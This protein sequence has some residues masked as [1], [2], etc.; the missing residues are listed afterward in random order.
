MRRRPNVLV[1][2]VLLAA[3]LLTVGGSAIAGASSS[4]KVVRG[5]TYRTA[6]SSFGLTDNL[7]PTGEY[8]SGFA[9]EIYAATLRTL[10]SYQRV[11]GPAG[12]LLY[13]DLATSMPTVTDGG[14][15]YTFHLK[16][17]IRF[18]PPVNS[19][20]TSADILFAFQRMNDA[21]LAAQYGFY[22]DGVIKGMTGT[23]KSMTAPIS[24]IDTPNASTIVFHLTKPTG[25]FL[26]RLAL[27]ATAPVPPEVGKCFTKAGAYGRDYI[28]SGPYMLQ[29]SQNL[30]IS[31]CSAMTPISGFDPTS[32]IILVRNPNYN[33]A[34]DSSAMRANYL[35]GVV[36]DIDTNVSDIFSRVQDGTLD[37]AMFDAPPAVVVH[38]YE[39]NS[40]LKAHL[41]TT[42]IMQLESITMNLAI[43]PFNNIHVRKAVA[44]VLDHAAIIDAL[45][46]STIAQNAT[47]LLPPVMTDNK[48][49]SSY[50]P[51]ASP[52]E[53]GNLA[54]AKAQM[55]LSPYDPKHDGKCDVSACNN[56]IF[57]DA[58]G[59]FTAIDPIVQ[60]D[61]AKI[62]I[63]ITPRDLETGAAFTAI[64]TVKN[65]VPMSALGG[66]Y[67]DYA[68]GYGFFEAA[69]ASTALGAT[70]CCNWA[71]VGL[72]KS[73]A[74][75][76][77]IP[78]PS[79][80]VPSVDAKL[81]Q[82][83]VLSGASRVNCWVAFDKYMMTDV[84]AWVPYMWG[85]YVNITAPDVTRYVVDQAT[86]SISL[87]QIAVSNRALP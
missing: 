8:Q 6:V 24:G 59:Q 45:G 15:T 58:Q 36:I 44:D 57:I 52:G 67:A 19:E 28:S 85:N 42:P 55:K 20:I 21:A 73:Q 82:C 69:F 54:A 22:F 30:K 37:G 49:T 62:G 64:E 66:G 63:Q 83:E 3:S 1:V 12:T 75:S 31:S 72:M 17:G 56:I 51:Y 77:G 46:G 18:A 40:S 10:V 68:D 7:D 14:L 87:T 11:S 47:H 13:P 25:D 9:W 81:N 4:G 70:G 2:V 33:S 43:P 60:A 41:H 86:G 78:Y 16:S 76:L 71:W 34:S 65:K 23:A 5:G 35:N 53:H 26:Y 27:P 84:V 61:L 38:N 29:G 50:N 79:N 39:T 80:G 74:K 48:L 32:H